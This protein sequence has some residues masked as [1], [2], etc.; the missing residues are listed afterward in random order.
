MLTTYRKTKAVMSNSVHSI[1]GPRNVL[2]IPP[3]LL[4]V[5]EDVGWWSGFNGASSGEPF[6]T[7][8]NRNHVPEDY[9]ALVRLAGKLGTQIVA[10][11]VLCEWDRK[12]FLAEIPSTTWMGKN[13]KGCRTGMEFQEQVVSILNENKHGVCP[14][15]HGVGHEY[16]L[17]GKADRTEFHNADGVMRCKNEVESH[18]RA[19]FR[20]YESTGLSLDSPRI[21]IPPALMHSYGNGEQGFQKILAGFG[22]RFVITVLE[23]ARSFKAPLFPTVTEDCGVVLVERGTAPVSW[24]TVA[25]DPVFAFDHPVLPLH[26]ANILDN[27]PARNIDVVDRWADHL[28]NG[29]EANGFVFLP[30]ALRSLRQ[31]VVSQLA[32]IR[33]DNEGTTL[34]LCPVNQVM[35]NVLHKTGFYVSLPQG[36]TLNENDGR[37]EPAGHIR[38]DLVKILPFKGVDILRL[39]ASTPDKA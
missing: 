34:D 20:L 6:R 22:I 19:F 37:I 26:W 8:M 28:K 4:V 2:Q 39:A 23:K 17:N 11:L 38:R 10:G 24:G 1:S 3:P 12:G 29:A 21:F 13:W 14:A 31:I 32:V 36:L 15:V 7:G 35:P 16:W 33:K 27:D 5:V 30:D 25:A 18:L 9:E